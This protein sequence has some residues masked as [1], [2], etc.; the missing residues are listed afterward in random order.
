MK[1]HLIKAMQRNQFVNM[2]YI[3]KSGEVSKRRIKSLRLSVIRFK[4]I[5][6]IDRQNVH[7]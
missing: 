2:M 5:V 1:E 6:S 3:A 7:L 4:L